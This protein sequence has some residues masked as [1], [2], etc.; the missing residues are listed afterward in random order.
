MYRDKQKI[1]FKKGKKKKKNLVGVDIREKKKTL[2]E[3]SRTTLQK[4]R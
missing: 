4:I 3:G 1:F 2:K